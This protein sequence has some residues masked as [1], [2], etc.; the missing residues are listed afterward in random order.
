[1]DFILILPSMNTLGLN[2]FSH[3]TKQFYIH[4]LISLDLQTNNPGGQIW[5]M[6]YSYLSDWFLNIISIFI[7]QLLFARHYFR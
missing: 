5:H 4:S 2:S 3:I 1:M 6:R 7:E